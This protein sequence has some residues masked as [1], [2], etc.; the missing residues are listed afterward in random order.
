M[1]QI[2]LHLD[3]LPLLLALKNKLQCG[4]ITINHKEAKGN[5]VL[6]SQ[7]GLFW[8]PIFDSFNL[9]TTQYLDYLAFR[10]V[11]ILRSMKGH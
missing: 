7:E 1:F 11:V 2:G 9:N 6:S 3:D 4:Y 5:Y 10:E 8:L